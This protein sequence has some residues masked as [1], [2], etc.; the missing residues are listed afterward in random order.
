MGLMKY[1]IVPVALS[2]FSLSSAEA[3]LVKCCQ[4]KDKS[5]C[6]AEAG[7]CEEDCQPLCDSSTAGQNELP[8]SPGGDRPTPPK[9]PGIPTTPGQ[10]P[11]PR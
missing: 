7:K 6:S 1:L 11:L 2:C 3:K 5:Y 8:S 9:Q 4:M 10:K